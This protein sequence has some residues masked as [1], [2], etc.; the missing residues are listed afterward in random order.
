MTNYYC[1]VTS[2]SLKESAIDIFNKRI[3]E[4][5][6]P[7]Y[8]RTPNLNEIKDDDE[9][10]FYI[11]GAGKERQSFVGQAIIQKVET[12]KEFLVDPDKDNH[13]VIKYLW[14]KKIKIFETSKNIQSIIDKLDFV[15]NKNNYGAYLM[16]GVKKLTQRDFNLIIS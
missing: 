5:K 3:E 6:Y 14:F 1:L 10:V 2:D 8:P 7:L 11:A 16:G 15:K 12:P 9:V 4:K 13:E